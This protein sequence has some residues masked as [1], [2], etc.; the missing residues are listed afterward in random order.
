MNDFMCKFVDR[1]VGGSVILAEHHAG[2][3][4]MIFNMSFMKIN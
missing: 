4:R 2:K 1:G 3:G